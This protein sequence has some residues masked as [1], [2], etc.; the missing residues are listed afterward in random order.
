MLAC[1]QVRICQHD[2]VYTNLGGV[3]S[4]V[5]AYCGTLVISDLTS[6]HKDFCDDIRSI[7]KSRDH[8]SLED[9]KIVTSAKSLL[10]WK[11]VS[12]Q[13]WGMRM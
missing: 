6:L 3:A 12:S 13:V 10:P 1:N 4:I 11:V 9:L 5:I 2:R 8:L 7:W